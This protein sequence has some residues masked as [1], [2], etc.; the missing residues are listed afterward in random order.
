MLTCGP[1]LMMSLRTEL[2]SYHYLSLLY[3][4]FSADSFLFFF[5]IV[6][7]LYNV[8]GFLSSLYSHY[9]WIFFPIGGVG[10]FIFCFSDL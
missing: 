6:F 8:L 3:I 10:G 4:L 2:T 5:H 1:D 7:N 9:L